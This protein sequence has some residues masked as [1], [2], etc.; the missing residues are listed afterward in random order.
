MHWT[1]ISG[2]IERVRDSQEPD[3]PVLAR[4]VKKIEPPTALI[5][6]PVGG[7]DIICSIESIPHRLWGVGHM[8][9]VVVASEPR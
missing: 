2:A 7:A 1:G 8:S 4:F 9:P 3:D 5:G 6:S